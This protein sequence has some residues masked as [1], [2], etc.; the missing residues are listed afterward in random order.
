MLTNT[1][2]IPLSLAVWLAHDT[3]DSN[4]DP[5][6]ISATMLLRPTKQV[7]LAKRVPAEDT[8]DISDVIASR[9]GTAIHDAIE[10]TW[11]NHNWLNGLVNLGYPED[12]IKRIIVNPTE[13]EMGKAELNGWPLIPIH[14]EQR[15]VREFKG[16]KIGGKFDMIVDGQLEDHKSTKTW[17][18][19]N[20]SNV[21]DYTKQSSIYRWL[22]EDIVS[23]ETFKINYIF[24]DYVAAKARI[25]PNYPQNQIIQKEY[26]L[27]SIDETETFI[28]NRL[29]LIDLYKDKEEDLIPAC[30]DEEL[31]RSDPTY[32]YYK[33]PQK[34]SRST[35]N[36]DNLA[37]AN[38]RLA[39]DGN[40]GIVVTVPGEV[41]RCNYCP[42]ASICKQ[43]QSYIDSGLLSPIE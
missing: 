7:I 24:T 6:Y 37:D 31:W 41:R 38:I 30:T 34:M 33:N 28:E 36:F 23:H 22:N 19:M 14:L 1:K 16:Y 43:R 2:N 18:Y 9:V 8:Q 17:G 39:E 26:P 29:S 12:M 27:M 42:G 40:V 3:Y 11:D 15:R 25:D 35:K 32:K 20:G 4:P 21:E 10:K 5:T 13:E